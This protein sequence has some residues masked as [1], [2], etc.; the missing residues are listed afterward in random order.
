MLSLL[1]YWKA[2]EKN[3]ADVRRCGRAEVSRVFGMKGKCEKCGPPY[4]GFVCE[5]VNINIKQ[6]SNG[7]RYQVSGSKYQVTGIPPLTHHSLLTT[8]HLLL[9][10]HCSPL[11]THHSLLTTHH[12]PLTLTSSSLFLGWPCW[13]AHLPLSRCLHLI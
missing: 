3:C 11:T 1:N 7:I 4:G 13:R 5:S 6:N 8:H 2:R 9:T 10:T 12:S